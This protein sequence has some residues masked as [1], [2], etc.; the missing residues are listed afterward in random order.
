MEDVY[1]KVTVTKDNMESVLYW[2]ETNYKKFIESIEVLYDIA[3]V[4]AVVLELIS[5]KEYEEHYV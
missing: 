3:K 4:D 1:Y 2:W 5:K